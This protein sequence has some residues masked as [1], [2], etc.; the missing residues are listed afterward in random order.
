M[1][2]ALGTSAGRDGPWYRVRT[3]RFEAA[4]VVSDEELDCVE[5]VEVRLA[6][7]SRW[8][9]TVFTVAEVGRLMAR[10]AD[11]GESLGGRY[12][13]CSDGLVVRDAGVTAITDVLSGLLDNGDFTSILRRC[14]DKGS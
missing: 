8:T 11:S 7:G 5:N 12:F 1:G 6:D 10:W 9:A 2:Q 3:T 14:A 13:W 4:F